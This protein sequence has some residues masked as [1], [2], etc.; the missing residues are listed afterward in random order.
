MHTDKSSGKL[1]APT[2]DMRSGLPIVTGYK[3]LECYELPIALKPRLPM[4]EL[5]KFNGSIMKFHSFWESFESSVD[6]NPGLSTIDKFNY[7]KASLEGSAARAI[8]GFSLT[9]ANYAA[10]TDIP[11]KRFGKTQQII[12]RHMDDLMKKPPM[13]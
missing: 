2:S 10:A 7:L 6:L 12:V 8:Q 3:S 1:G 11:K 13:F 5:L 9:E 4:I